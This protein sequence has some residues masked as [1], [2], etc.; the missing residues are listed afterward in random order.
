[1]NRST[2]VSKRALFYLWPFGLATWMWGTVFI[3]RRDKRQ[4]QNILNK[5]VEVIKKKK[6]CF[7][8]PLRLLI[9]LKIYSFEFSKHSCLVSHLLQI[10][11]AK[12]L[13]FAEGTRNSSEKLLPFKKGAFHIA[14]DAECSIQPVVVSRYYYLDSKR[15]NFSSGTNKFHIYVY[16]KYY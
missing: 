8:L 12:L 2:V 5:Q 16:S 1:M 14:L 9:L 11:Q 10:S 3:D 13:L 15:P 6:V 7:I 4:A